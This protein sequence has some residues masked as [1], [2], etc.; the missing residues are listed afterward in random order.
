MIQIGFA[1]CLMAPG[2][3]MFGLA[4]LIGYDPYYMA[5][6]SLKVLSTAIRMEAMLSFVLALNRMKIICG[7]SY[8]AVV[9]KV[10]LLLSWLFGLLY[11]IAFFSPYCDYIVVPGRYISKYDYSYPYSYL[12]KKVGSFV[13]VHSTVMTLFVYLIIIVYLVVIKLK[14]GKTDGFQSEKRILLYAA[15]RF[16]FDTFLTVTYNFVHLPSGPWLEFVNYMV[17]VA[18]NLVVPPVVYLCLYR[19]LRHCFWGVRKQQVSPIVAHLQKIIVGCTYIIVPVILI[20]AYLRIVYM[21]AT[22]KK[23][24]SLECYRIMIHIGVIQCAMGPGVFLY[25]LMQ[26]LDYDPW[27]I[28][29]YTMRVMSSAVRMEAVMSFVLALNRLKVICDLHYPDWLHTAILIVVWILGTVNY[30]LL[31]TP[32]FGYGAEPG[33]FSSHYDFS[34]PYSFILQQIGSYFMVCSFG[35]SMIVYIAII[36]YLLRLR[37]RTGLSSSFDSEKHILIYAG[38]RFIVDISLAIVFNYG[39]LPAI[40]EVDFPVLLGY[41]LNN[42]FLPPALYL[43][44]NK[45]LRQEFFSFQNQNTDVYVL[46][47]S[48]VTIRPKAPMISHES[49]K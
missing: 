32:W 7:L 20:P 27:N 45:S 47:P 22:R 26:L 15:I 2:T 42:F 28:G 25:G 35:L 37:A 9:H 49:T 10:L 21:Y 48:V 4:N 41:V 34:K 40:P 18:N 46:T 31:Y 11:L 3:F 13:L 44:L 38:V 33:V 14:I 30:V 8:P 43:A 6:A 24:R 16:V 5:A 29:T 12:L 19:S 23:Y 17:Y 39:H 36:A 1:Q